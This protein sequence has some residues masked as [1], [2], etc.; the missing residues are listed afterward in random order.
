LIAAI[1]T[2][3]LGFSE[4]APA[5]AAD[6]RLLPRIHHR[7]DYTP[8]DARPSYQPTY[9]DRPVVYRPYGLVPFFFGLS[10]P[11]RTW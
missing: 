10:F 2:G 7:R 6:S 4:I 9:Y 1:V 11:Y 8:P 5:S 3:L